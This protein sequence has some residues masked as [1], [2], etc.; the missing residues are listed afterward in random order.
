MSFTFAGP[1]KPT[2]KQLLQQL[3][4]TVPDKWSEIGI[5][6]EIPVSQREAIDQKHK[7][8]PQKCLMAMLTEI[9]LPRVSPPPTWQEIANAVEC[10]GYPDVA[11]KLRDQFCECFKCR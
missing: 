9:W 6:L 1:N 8:N 11:Q 7:G 3:Y 10:V 2:E 4:N 5:Y